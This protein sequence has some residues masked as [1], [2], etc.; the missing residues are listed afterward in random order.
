MFPAKPAV[1]GP[2]ACAPERLTPELAKKMATLVEITD[3]DAVCQ[4]AFTRRR[5]RASGEIGEDFA[6]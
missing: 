2:G 5:A 1:T 4:G 3:R 6:A